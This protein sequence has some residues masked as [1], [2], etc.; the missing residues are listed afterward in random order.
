[1]RIQFLLLLLTLIVCHFTGEAYILPEDS[2]VDRDLTSLKRL[3]QFKQTRTLLLQLLHQI[4]TYS[5]DPPKV[6]VDTSILVR[7]DNSLGKDS[8]QY[9][10]RGNVG[11]VSEKRDMGIMPPWREL[12]RLAGLRN[13]RGYSR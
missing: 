8:S 5:H 4:N 11:L 1:M 7:G 3:T 12:C 2:S 13:C 10:G 9:E 6:Y